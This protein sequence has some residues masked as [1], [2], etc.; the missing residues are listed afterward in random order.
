MDAAPVWAKAALRRPRTRAR[1]SSKPTVRVRELGMIASG[2]T[3][4]CLKGTAVPLILDIPRLMSTVPMHY[5]GPLHD[6]TTPLGC[7][8]GRR[9]R[10]S[11]RPR[12]AA[13]ARAGRSG[14][15]PRRAASRS[16]PPHPA[17]HRAR[18][19]SPRPVVLPPRL[20]L[21][22]LVR[23]D[24][25]HPGRDPDRPPLPHRRGGAHPGPERGARR[26]G[27]GC[28]SEEH[29]SELQ[30]RRDLVCRLLLEKKKKKIKRIL[31][32]KKKKKKY[33]K[34]KKEKIK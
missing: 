28:R 23:L 21:V 34:K 26:S 9:P 8:G 11:S 15:D 1:V 6:T 14:R 12:P 25:G 22:Q 13:L 29:T 2:D 33:K 30:S 32:K 16:T 3:A 7:P 4:R 5:A 24:P 18:H 19:R 20:P 31:L 10:R 17:A 27:P